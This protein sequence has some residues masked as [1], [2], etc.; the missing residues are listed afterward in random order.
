[1]QNKSS[2]VPT[3]LNIDKYETR[4]DWYQTGFKTAA[5]NLDVSSVDWQIKLIR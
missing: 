5:M 3:I 4:Q 2:E 1:M